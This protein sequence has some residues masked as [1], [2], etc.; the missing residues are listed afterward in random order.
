MDN[1]MHRAVRR[2]DFAPRLEAAAV[3]Q[4]AQKV[5]RGRYRALS[6]REGR[7]KISV[8][9]YDGAASLR[10]QLA[11]L[12]ADINQELAAD[13]VSQIIITVKPID[14]GEVIS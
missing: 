9:D 3:C 7:L 14:S 13:A 11:T 4:A 2:M 5:A 12:Q 1:L 8:P 10:P 6:Y